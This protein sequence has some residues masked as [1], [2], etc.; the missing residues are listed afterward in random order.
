MIVRIPCG[1]KAVRA[2]YVTF[3]LLGRFC[4]SPKIEGTLVWGPL[5]SETPIY[6]AP[7]SLGLVEVQVFGV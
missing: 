7:K 4:E 3:D 5:F 2:E 1:L 6:T